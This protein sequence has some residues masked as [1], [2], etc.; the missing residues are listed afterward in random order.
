VCKILHTCRLIWF[1]VFAHHLVSKT[2]QSFGNFHVVFGTLDN[3]QSPET[4]QTYTLTTVRTSQCRQKWPSHA[5]PTQASNL[6]LAIAT[7]AAL[8]LRSGQSARLCHQP[9]STTLVVAQPTAV[10][11]FAHLPERSFR[12]LRRTK[13]EA[14]RARQPWSSVCPRR[15]LQPR[16]KID[17]VS[18]IPVIAEGVC[19]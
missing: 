14:F 9:A 12:W 19:H 16:W 4:K 10:T 13:G 3:R 17:S 1:L 2:I 5:A 15:G 8:E 18:A 6:T 11:C 7:R